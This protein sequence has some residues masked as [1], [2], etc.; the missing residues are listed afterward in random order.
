MYV[1]S[2]YL[3]RRFRLVEKESNAGGRVTSLGLI[4]L[5]SA[6]GFDLIT[7]FGTGLS[8]VGGSNLQSH[9]WG[10]LV[11]G[12]VTMNFPLPLGIIHEASDFL[13]FSSLVPPSLV[14]L[15]RAG[16]ITRGLWD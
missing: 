5:F 2:G 12:L 11:F 14:L 4:G 16:L 10:A 6:V 7:N 1:L 13:F 15:R 9:L 8:V 3:A